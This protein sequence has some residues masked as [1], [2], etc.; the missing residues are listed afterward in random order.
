M[1]GQKIPLRNRKEINYSFYN[2]E[3]TYTLSVEIAPS[4]GLLSLNNLCA[5]TMLNL[6]V[7]LDFQQVIYV[8]VKPEL[9][10]GQAA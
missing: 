4:G 1:Y 7:S 10:C 2:I 5:N 9:A 8:R 3:G 6:I